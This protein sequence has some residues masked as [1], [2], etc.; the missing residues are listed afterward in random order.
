MLLSPRCSLSLQNKRKAFT[1][2][3]SVWY[4]CIYTRGVQT[5]VLYTPLDQI[6]IVVWSIILLFIFAHKIRST[7]KINPFWRSPSL[8]KWF[9]FGMMFVNSANSESNLLCVSSVVSFLIWGG[10]GSI[11]CGTF[12]LLKTRNY[13]FVEC[14]EYQRIAGQKYWLETEKIFER[15]KSI[16]DRTNR[17]DWLGSPAS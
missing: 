14:S 11:F 3:H 16:L 13:N 9:F 7:R 12:F 2:P 4:I 8:N 1:S 17:P 5:I 15:T 6:E 10:G